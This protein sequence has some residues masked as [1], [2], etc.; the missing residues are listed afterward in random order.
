MKSKHF[1]FHLL[2]NAHLDP[3]WL[4]DWREGLNEGIVTV[5]TI[6]NLMDEF[7]QLT[8]MRGECAIYEHIEKYDPATFKRIER[9]VDAGRWDVVGGTYIQPDS[10]LAAT[11][12]LCRQFERGLKYFESRFGRRPKI[13]WQADSFGHTPSWPNILDAFGMEGFTFTRPQRSEFPMKSPAFWW[14]T[15]YNKPILCYRQH[16]MWYCSER[17]NLVEKLDFTLKSAGDQPFKNV[18]LLMGLGN[19]GGG[20]SRRHIEEAEKW[21]AAHPEVELR[22]ST[23]HGMFDDLREELAALPRS[24]APAVKGDLGYCLRGCYSSVSKFKSVYRHAEALVAEAAI[25]QAII[26]STVK[27]ADGLAPAWDGVLFNAFHDILPGSSIER[28]FDDQIAWVGHATHLARSVCF[29]S[30]NQLAARVDTTVPPAMA[31]DRATDVPVLIWNPL[32][33]T[34]KQWFEIEESLDYRHIAGYTTELGTLPLFLEGPD[35]KKPIFQD[36]ET[37]HHSMRGQAWR[38]RVAVYDELPPLGWKLYRFGYRTEADPE[39]PAPRKKG[40]CTA[41]HSPAPFV[42]NEDWHVSIT[43][44]GES[45]LRYRGQDLLEKPGVIQVRLF[46]DPWGSWGGMQEETDSTC[47]ENVRETW[48]ITRAEIRD[49]G[50]HRSSLWTRWQGANS[51]LELTFCVGEKARELRVFGRLLINER[52]ARVKLVFPRR[53]PLEMEVP[54]GCIKRNV[55]GHL[56]TGRW[57]TTGS[58]KNRLHFISDV[59]GDVDATENEFRVTLARASRYADDVRTSPEETPWFPAVDCGE[60]KFQFWLAVGNADPA[61]LAEQLLHPPVSLHVAPHPGD[62]GRMGSCGALEPTSVKLLSAQPLTSGDISLR[63]QNQSDRQTTVHWMNG[64]YKLTIAT[65]RPWEI[66]SV[67]VPAS[68]TIPTRI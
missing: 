60:L 42:A 22:F 41:G 56:P 65:L 23:L 4:W 40:T 9:M 15:G 49:K 63:L 7:P 5:R 31:A 17:F 62:L 54:G 1:T 39:K 24:V 52:S 2:P 26:N 10:N 64:K 28:A 55:P 33:R 36:I 48:R 47:L 43:R 53:G 34:V 19:H 21:A 58:G 67:S 3:V 44:N 38:K 50:P 37:E 45:R 11:E 59:L 30:L 61:L 16:W 20:P 8:F 68:A 6:L 25:T 35:G 66:A 18:G 13:A 14:N 32:P 51:W 29:D 27:A 57:V 12:T 46:E